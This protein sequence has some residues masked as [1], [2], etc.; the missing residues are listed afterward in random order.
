MLVLL[1]SCK[2]DN[3]ESNNPKIDPQ[4]SVSFCELADEYYISP[5]D[6]SKVVY[7]SFK[8]QLGRLV[9]I[10]RSLLQMGASADSL[11]NII[12]KNDKAVTA[13][14]PL[15]I[16]D[17]LGIGDTL[18]K[19]IYD[20]KDRL[21]EVYFYFNGQI[22]RH[23]QFTYNENGLDR[24]I[25]SS[26][27]YKGEYDVIL[28]NGL[29][30]E[31]ILIEENG[32]P[33]DSNYYREQMKYDENLN[34]LYKVIDGS[35]SRFDYFNKHNMT[36]FKVIQNG[37]PQSAQGAEYVYDYNSFDYPIKTSVIW[38]AGGGY[39]TY[40]SYNCAVSTN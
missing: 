22:F 40:K 9:Q 32:T 5:F 34:P 17:T 27:G 28:E 24:Y 6:S 7:A 31:L 3:D 18:E 23:D 39:S 38:A 1:F 2:K 8:Y 15:N 13:I 25:S 36:E 14:E 12:W 37:I 30:A 33:V 11:I 10:D 4:G 20:D 29:I 16:I 19:Y 26:N 35:F 21:I